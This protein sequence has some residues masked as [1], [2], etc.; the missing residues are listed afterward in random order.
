MA[1][2]RIDEAR[3]AGRAAVPVQKSARG[4]LAEQARAFDPALSYDIFLSHSFDDAE[5]IY[6]IKRMIE[7]LNL[8][9]YVDWID[10]PMLDRGEVTVKTAAVLRERM[11]ACSSLVYAHS[12]NS[13][14]SVWMPWELGYFDGVKPQQ[15][16]VLPLVT[17]DDSEFRGQEYL[18]LYPPVEKLGTLAGRIKL[19]FDRV[20][21]HKRQVLLENAARGNGVFFDPRT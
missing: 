11:K 1:Y 10:D 8:R 12:A 2:I 9:V 16:W 7:A 17:N 3:A 18:G 19:G 4:I 21:N 6:G 20:G 15:V 5:A 14:N 13:S